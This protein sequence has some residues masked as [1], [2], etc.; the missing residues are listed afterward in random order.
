MC[1]KLLYFS[2]ISYFYMH[3]FPSLTLFFQFHSILPFQP[4]VMHNLC[5]SLSIKR[6]SWK[7]SLSHSFLSP[8]NFELP[9]EGKDRDS[10]HLELH[11][12]RDL[13]A[14]LARLTLVGRHNL[15]IVQLHDGESHHLL[16]EGCHILLLL[17]L[18][19]L[20]ELQAPIITSFTKQAW[21][22]LLVDV[23]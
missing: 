20:Q 21:L 7:H 22:D 5:L 15:L 8:P 18:L 17:T 2:L 9:H 12:I 6:T 4:S 11:I 3:Y 1:M 14:E 13:L 10:Y 23:F 19:F 16:L